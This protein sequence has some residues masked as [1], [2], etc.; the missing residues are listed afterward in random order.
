MAEVCEAAVE[1]LH[2]LLCNGGAAVEVELDEP[3]VRAAAIHEHC[4]TPVADSGVCV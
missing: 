1:R 3:H 2:A 4:R